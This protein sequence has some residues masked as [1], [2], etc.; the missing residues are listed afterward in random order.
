M[1]AKKT[2]Q[3]AEPIKIKLPNSKIR[4]FVAERLI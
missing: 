1:I 2:I 4:S 3:V